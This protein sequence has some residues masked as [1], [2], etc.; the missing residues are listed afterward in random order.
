MKIPNPMGFGWS[1]L[2][3]V[4]Y[5]QGCL[6]DG[7]HSKRIGKIHPFMAYNIFEHHRFE[8]D[9][10]WTRTEPPLQMGCPPSGG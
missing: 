5:V 1:M 7:L 9:L 3:Y 8:P 2:V 6:W 4:L 10:R